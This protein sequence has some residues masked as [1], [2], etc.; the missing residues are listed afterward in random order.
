MSYSLELRERVVSFVEKG[1]SRKSASE[2]FSVHYNTVKAWVKQFR[3]RGCLTPKPMPPRP[4]YKLEVAV[5][6]QQVKEHP[7]WFQHEQA[8]SFGV[9][10]SAISKAFAKMGLTRKKTV[11]L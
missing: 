9:T 7:D 11:S 1:N 5:L 2:V 4:P 10:P 8:E 6:Q 3:E